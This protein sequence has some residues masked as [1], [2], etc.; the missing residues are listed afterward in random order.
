MTAVAD[1]L[2][3]T[4]HGTLGSSSR[5]RLMA[6]QPWLE[7]AGFQVEVS[8][9]FDDAYL[10]R[11]YADGRAHGGDVLG[12]FGRRLRVLFRL[13]RYRLLWIEKELFPFLPGNV[14]GL[15]P[16]L[17]VPYVLDY[18]DATFHRYDLHRSRLV[19]TL[20]GRRLLPLLRGAT[21]V[22]AGNAYL[23][24]YARGAGAVD[25]RELPTVLDSNRYSVADE[26]AGEELRIGWI[27]SPSTAHYLGL[28]LDAL[29]RLA[30]ERP[31]RLVV[32]GAR[33]LPPTDVPLEL[34]DWSIDTESALLGSVHIGI[35]PLAEGPWERGKCGYK[36]VQY[37]AC[38][39][40]VIAS[41]VGVNVD[42]VT[43]A[44]GFLAADSRQ[45]LAALRALAADAA[46]RRRMGAAGRACVEADYS[47]QTW[48]PR[49]AT[50]LAEAASISR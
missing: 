28:V 42:I 38:G 46:L 48:G 30:R 40:P 3:L 45:W 12:A 33:E 18:D 50:L 11:L 24:D 31:L 15:L 29:R 34:H 47:L 22:T 35:M 36:L 43:P 14:D 6:Y 19:R 37:M 41:P 5:L 4:R 23:A 20:L 16:R 9:F 17:G 1:L 27:G 21:L 26:P 8:P 49:V 25:V 2:L 32:I 39:K 7:R 13:R 10:H 44:R